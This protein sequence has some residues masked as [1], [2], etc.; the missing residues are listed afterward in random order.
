MAINAVTELKLQ[1]QKMSASNDHMPFLRSDDFI[2]STGSSECDEKRSMD[3]F[4]GLRKAHNP[5]A[6]HNNWATQLVH[7]AT[8]RSDRSSKK[9][10]DPSKQLASTSSSSPSRQRS[11]DNQDNSL[12]MLHV[13]YMDSKLT[14]LL[15]DSLGGNSRTVMITTLSPEA[16]NYTQNLY[17]LSLAIKASKVLNKPTSN[18]S[19]IVE[20][21][22]SYVPVTRES[23]L[24][25]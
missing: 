21:A 15:R 3:S 19:K 25:S 1:Q 16:E 14:L 8:T 9:L 23:K 24:I 17:A 12:R 13:P 10:S 4:D 11:A 20:R 6:A 5:L 18:W 22:S 2:A 7:S